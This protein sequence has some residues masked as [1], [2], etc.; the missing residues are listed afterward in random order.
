M[1]NID[2]IQESLDYIEENLQAQLQVEE[3]AD[4]AGYSLFH[5]YRFFQK[6]VGLPDFELS[7]K[8]VRIF[9]VCY[10]TTAIL[11]ENFQKDEQEQEK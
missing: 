4:M 7:E 2:R 8:N 10:M 6:L 11:S 9:D 5:Y 3:L 1:Q